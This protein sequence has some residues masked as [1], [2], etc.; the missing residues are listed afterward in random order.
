MRSASARIV[1]VT[2][3]LSIMMGGWR[4]P[5]VTT[6]LFMTGKQWTF[7]E[8]LLPPP[9]AAGRHEKHPRLT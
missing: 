8:L 6:M 5:V 3:D 2:H 1:I 4:L 7:L 9:S